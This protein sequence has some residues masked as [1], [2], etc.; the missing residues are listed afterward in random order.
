MTKTRKP[1]TN[2]SKNSERANGLVQGKKHVSVKKPI[3]KNIT[4]DDDDFDEDELNIDLVK[5]TDIG[6]AGGYEFFDDDD[7]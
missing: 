5:N 2:K 3:A 4:N 7:F 6:I 1:I